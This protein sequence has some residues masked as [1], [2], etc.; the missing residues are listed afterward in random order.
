MTVCVWA[1]VSDG[2]S[3]AVL[4]RLLCDFTVTVH[5]FDE[6]CYGGVKGRIEQRMNLS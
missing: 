5:V 2:L 1:A 6:F 4:E 3:L